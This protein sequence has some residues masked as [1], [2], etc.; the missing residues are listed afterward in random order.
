VLQWASSSSPSNSNS[1]TADVRTLVALVQAL[2]MTPNKI[3]NENQNQNDPTAHVLAQAATRLVMTNE[4]NNND[5]TNN[6]NN[7]NCRLSRIL[8]RVLEQASLSTSSLTGANSS[9]FLPTLVV[10]LVW[11]VWQQFPY[12]IHATTIIA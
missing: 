11:T 10:P 3:N 9:M 7:S 12:L 4:P 1:N 8:D 5:A 6:N 2:M